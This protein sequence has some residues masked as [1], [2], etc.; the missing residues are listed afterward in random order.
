MENLFNIWLNLITQIVQKQKEIATIR[1]ENY[2]IFKVIHMTS[3]E[4]SIHSAFIADLLN[5]KGLHGMGDEF[6]RLFINT[7]NMH[8][9][10]FDTEGS[11]VEIEKA[12]GQK[13]IE[14][15]SGGRLDIIITN[16]KGQAIII[17]NKINAKDQEAQMARYL[18]YANKNH[19]DKCLLLYLSLD[20][21][22]HDVDYTT[23]G[24][25]K[26]DEDFYS[27]SYRDD[28]L[29][30]LI[31]CRQ[32]AVDKPL[33]REGLSHYINLVKYLTHTNMNAQAK[34]EMINMVMSNPSYIKNLHVYANAIT[35]S[36]QALT[37]KFWQE[38]YVKMQLLVY[39]NLRL[40]EIQDEEYNVISIVKNPDAE[41]LKGSASRFCLKSMRK[42]GYNYK[43]GLAYP[44][45]EKNGQLLIAGIMVHSAVTFRVYAEDSNGYIPYSEV[46]SDFKRIREMLGGSAFPCKGWAEN[47]YIC[48]K[49]PSNSEMWEFAKMDDPV[50]ENLSDMDKCIES[51]LSEFMSYINGLKEILQEI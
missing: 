42:K 46:N 38:L 34:N 20:G 41:L 39:E 11:K 32:I 40:V 45:S 26:I 22:V 25:A 9:H 6:L 4:T 33:L 36:M 35:S 2:N 13:K 27:I 1:G 8:G 49:R 16:K 37:I 17:E 50:L 5:P 43:F 30:W 31:K 47:F 10:T 21:Q 23:K 18:K 44:V 24:K 19:K 3:N 14:D 48:A 51:I 12:I 29:D 15:L 28:I 7:I